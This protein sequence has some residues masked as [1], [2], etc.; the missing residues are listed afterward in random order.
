MACGVPVVATTVGAFEE[1]IVD[2]K[3]GFLVPPGAPDAIATAIGRLLDDATL[4]EQR[5]LVARSHI[6]TGFRIKDEAAAITAIY[7]GLLGGSG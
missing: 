2:G 6:E 7:S 3:T 1:L 4:R 5:S